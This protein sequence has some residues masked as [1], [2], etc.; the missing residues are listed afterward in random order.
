MKEL[1]RIEKDRFVLNN[2]PVRM[3]G[4][5]FQTWDMPWALFRVYKL[6]SVEAG[7]DD[8]AALGCNCVRAWISI[9]NRR[10]QDRFADFVERAAQRGLRIYAC[11]S[12]KAR[13]GTPPD[14]GRRDEED[15]AGVARTWRNDPRI[16]AYDI[17]N[18]PDWIS[19]DHWQWG[20]EP[21][22]AARRIEWLLAMMRIIRAEDGNHPVSVGLTF[23]DSWWTPGPALQ[24]L[25]A[26]DF[27]DFH[28]YHRTYRDR[29]LAEAIRE[30]KARTAKPVLAGEIG[31]STDP[32]YSVEGEPVHSEAV[33][34]EIYGGY[35][36]DMIEEPI[37]GCLQ[38]TLHDYAHLKPEQGETFYGLLR[39]DRTWKP[40]ARVFRDEVPGSDLKQRV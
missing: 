33:Q 9:R 5:N 11:F 37:A 13:F 35:A 32:D 6:S 21:A 34:E 15:L 3:K 14:E 30:V 12:W 20:M 39:S 19:H 2:A 38:W 17:I 16:F 18:E 4:T 24:L 1:I 27:V 8:A 10:E 25:E 36:R 26:A 40:A 31:N 7:L 29:S 22:A 28:Y 23:N